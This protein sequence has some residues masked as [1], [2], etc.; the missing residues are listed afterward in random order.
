MA[1]TLKA[2]QQNPDVYAKTAFIINYDEGGKVMCTCF[3]C[4]PT[5]QLYSTYSCFRLLGKRR[6]FVLCWHIFSLLAVY[7]SCCSFFES[8]LFRKMSVQTT[9]EFFWHVKESGVSF[10]SCLERVGR[11]GLRP[12]E[13]RASGL[14]VVFILSDVSITF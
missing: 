12:F 5:L 10:I 6:C 7:P 13:V 8:S 11:E 3:C 9:A 1:R 2:L 4:N 14:M